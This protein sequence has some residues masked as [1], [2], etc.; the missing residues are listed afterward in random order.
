MSIAIS[1]VLALRVAIRAHCAG[2]AVLAQ[3]TSGAIRLYDASA[4]PTSS[5]S[6]SSPPSGCLGSAL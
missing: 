3:L 5:A 6:P 2:D 1:P 4:R